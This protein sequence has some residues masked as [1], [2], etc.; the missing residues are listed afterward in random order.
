ML[1]SG[2][3]YFPIPEPETRITRTRTRNSRSRNSRLLIR[4]GVLISRNNLG[5]FGKMML[6]P[7]KPENPEQPSSPIAKS[8]P[9]VLY[10]TK[11]TSTESRLPLTRTGISHPDPHTPHHAASLRHCR[12]PAAPRASALPCRPAVS[13]HRATAASAPPRRIRAAASHPATSAFALHRATAAPPQPAALA[14]AECGGRRD[15]IVRPVAVMEEEEAERC[16]SCSGGSGN[17]DPELSG[18]RIFGI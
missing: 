9:G 11:K 14:A 4:E 7:E 12:I 10:V 18:T 8:P 13:L 1:C 2:W 15:L 6:D 17:P 5:K 3:A 16:C